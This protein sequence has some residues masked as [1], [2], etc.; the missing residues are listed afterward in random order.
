M[1]SRVGLGRRRRYCPSSPL[2]VVWC[3][4]L[5]ALRRKKINTSLYERSVG[6]VEMLIISHR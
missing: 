2:F 1:T 3:S 4:L 5:S 6:S